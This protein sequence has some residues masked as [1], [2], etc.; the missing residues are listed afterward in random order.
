M[1]KTLFSPF[2]IKTMELS[3]RLVV[4]PMVVNYCNPDGTATEKWMTYLEARAKG[5][6]GLIITEDFAVDPRGKGFSRIPGLWNDS[7]VEGHAELTRRI[8]QH[9]AKVMAQIYHAGRQTCHFVTGELPLA[10]SPIPCPRLQELPLELKI[11]EIEEIVEKFGDTALRAKKAGFDGVEIHGAHGYLISGFMS[12]YSNKRTDKYGG[13]LMNRLR[14]PLEIIAN[15]RAKVGREFIVGFRISGD[16]FVPGGRSIEDT[17]YVAS[18][19]EENSIDVLHITAGVYA[20]NERIMG[21]SMTNHG[22]IADLAAE[23]KKMVSIPVITVNRI[24]DPFVAEVVLR[25][26]KAD[27]VSMARGSLSDPELPNKAAA[28]RFDD[29]TYCIACMQGCLAEVVQDKP[30]R[31]IVNPEVGREAEFAA[32]RANAKKKKVLVIGGGP[33]GMEAAVSAAKTGHEVSLYEKKNKLGGQFYLAAVPPGKGEITSFISALQNQLT[34][35]K[36]D[37]HLNAEVT[38]E[39]VMSQK[40]DVVIVATGSRPSA[41]NVPGADL[42]HVVSAYD[43]LEGKIDVGPRVVVIGGGMVG[44]ETASHMANHSKQVVIVEQLPEIAMDEEQ[45]AVRPQLLRELARNNVRIRVNSTVSQISRDS[46]TIVSGNL[47][48]SEPVDSVV[49]A[50]G[51]VP[52][53]E[54]ISELEG[55]L[56]KVICVGDVCGIKNA[57]EATWDGYA[58]GVEL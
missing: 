48:E 31:C 56:F 25:S 55:S 15:I 18:V 40:P 8:H 12:A 7:Q 35:L 37:V 50:V 49:I 57:L 5:G 21:D 6:F 10:P 51:A 58:A 1:L 45:G 11:P 46:V 33:A 34:S 17:K 44:A 13:N 24:N 38:P 43:V 22:M 4:A 42:P 28:G 19:L 27:L 2:K 32:K 9:G 36:V 26:G 14:F 30:V 41:L 53:N 52:A 20:S 29:I 47:T 16:E 39:M 3:N 23:V 54:L